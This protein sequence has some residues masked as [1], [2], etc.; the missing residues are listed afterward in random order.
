[1]IS[2]SKSDALFGAAV[3]NSGITKYVYWVH[4]VHSALWNSVLSGW[5]M[6]VGSIFRE[7]F[8]VPNNQHVPWA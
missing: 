5:S 8:L 3:R 6:S 4:F 2:K 7:V 1:M